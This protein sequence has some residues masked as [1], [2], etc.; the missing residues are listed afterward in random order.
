MAAKV[1]TLN[2]SLLVSLILNMSDLWYAANTT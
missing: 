2:W 1:Q